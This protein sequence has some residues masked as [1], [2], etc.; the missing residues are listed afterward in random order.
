[1][2]D[3]WA[4]AFSPTMALLRW[5][6]RPVRLET[7]REVR[8][9]LFGVDA[10]GVGVDVAAGFEGHDDFFEGG[11]AGAFADAVDGAFDLTGAALDGG[12]GIGDGEAEVVVA[13][14]R[15]SRRF[16]RRGRGR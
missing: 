12:E 4:K 14:G 15:R 7:R 2:P 3:S 5:T 16:W 6:C 13:R 11:V 8:D 1:M 9:E 10:G